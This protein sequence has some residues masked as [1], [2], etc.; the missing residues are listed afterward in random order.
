VVA[1]RSP[2]RSG[3]GGD[4]L[5][6]WS[7]GRPASRCRHGYSSAAVPDPARPKNAYARE[8]Q[9][10]PHLTA[11]AIL[12]AAPAGIPERRAAGPLR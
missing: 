5:S 2:D 12:P 1:G 3:T 4:V 10:L 11:I 7:Y 6:S 9:I 8:D